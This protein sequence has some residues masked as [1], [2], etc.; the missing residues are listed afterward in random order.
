MQPNAESHFKEVASILHLLLC[1]NFFFAPVNDGLAPLVSVFLV[2]GKDWD[3]GSVGV[4]WFARDIAA[5]TCQT[6]AGA[7]VDRSEHKK[8]PF[9][10]ATVAASNA[11]TSIVSLNIMLQS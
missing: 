6:F 7:L 9:A 10:L 8:L 11:A 1:F 4:V 5:L 2:V 3:T